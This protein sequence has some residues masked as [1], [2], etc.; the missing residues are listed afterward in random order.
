MRVECLTLS[1]KVAATE[2]DTGKRDRHN[3][4]A[5]FTYTHA[6]DGRKEKAVVAR[7]TGMSNKKLS[8]LYYP[9]MKNQSENIYP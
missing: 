3:F 1:V 6:K 5:L 9:L 2:E 4:C 7:S 8:L